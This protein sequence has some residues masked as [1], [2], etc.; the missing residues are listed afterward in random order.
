M[1]DIIN[2][3]DALIDDQLEAGEPIGG[4]DFGDPDYPKCPHCQGDWHGLAITEQMQRMRYRG[5]VDE[6]YRY[7]EDDSPVIC[8]GSEFI[9]PVLGPQ[10]PKAGYDNGSVLPL[11]M[12]PDGFVRAVRELWG[13]V[14]TGTVSNHQTHGNTTTFDFTPDRSE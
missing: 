2:E 4:Y 6:G 8:P 10:I 1:S 7:S 13:Q 9:G 12:V 3:I 5:A 14:V 11:A